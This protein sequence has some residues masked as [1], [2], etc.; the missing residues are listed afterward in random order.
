MRIREI[1]VLG[2]AAA[3]TPLVGTF[4]PLGLAPLLVVAAVANLVLRVAYDRD[5][6]W[7]PKPAIFLFAAFAALGLASAIWSYNP[8]ATLHKV[9]LLAGALAC[10]VVLLD[11]LSACDAEQRA[12]IG[13]R[14]FA[15]V[16]IALA[17]LVVERVAGFPLRHIERASWPDTHALLVSYNRGAT[18]LALLVWPAAIVMWRKRRLYALLLVASALAILAFYT[19]GAALAAIIIGAVAF[20]LALAWPR[21]IAAT[22]MAGM[23]VYIVGSP[24]IHD[25]VLDADTLGLKIEK[26]KLN[27]AI[28]PRSGFHR[29]LIWRF[30]A[31]KIAERPVLGWGLESSRFIPGG[32]SLLDPAE[33]ALPLHPH[34]GVLQI[35]LELGIPG[36][37]LLA[38]LV[39]WMLLRVRDAPW[40]A[41]DKAASLALVAAAFVI[42]NLS[43][44]IWQGWWVAAL[45][46]AATFGVGIL[47]AA[48]DRRIRLTTDFRPVAANR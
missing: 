1:Q 9:P 18:V 38:G 43:Y 2:A 20:G 10:G 35:W 37:A 31:Q 39:T 22:L 5:R 33:Q 21:A 42:V 6:P 7:R 24:V 8:G 25:R 40:P 27:S 28:V 12:L 13:R 48:A 3:L 23:I 34:N 36:I 45:L 32:K 17:I 14:L 47:P 30:T 44:G 26:D 15:G 19:S 29:L 16:V 11:A 46:F 4:E 41:V